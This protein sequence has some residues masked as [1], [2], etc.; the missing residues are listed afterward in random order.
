VVLAGA[1]RDKWGASGWENGALGYLTG[2]TVCG[3]VDTGCFQ[4]FQG[5]S[6][7]VSGSTVAAVVA[8]P[9][10]DAWAAT[11]WEG[12]LL[13]YPTGDRICGYL[14][15][16]CAQMFQRGAITTT[17]AAPHAVTGPVASEWTAR[18]AAGGSLGVALSDLTCGLAEGGCFQQFVGG[19]IYSSPAGAFVVTGAIGDRWAAGGWE[20]GLGYPLGDQQ[21]G[22]VNN[23]CSQAFEHGTVFSSGLTSAH[24]LSGDVLARYLALG[25]PSQLG[26]PTGEAA[27]TGVGGGTVTEFAWGPTMYSNSA[28][29]EGRAIYWSSATGAHLVEGDI[30]Q[31]YEA[32]RQVASIGYPTDDQHLYEVSPG[33]GIVDWI[34]HFERGTHSQYVLGGLVN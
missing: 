29:Y 26:Y 2:D 1:V 18:G 7:Y 17:G 4:A 16:G 8:S 3:L 23:G 30:L 12:G 33:S 5:G 20:R 27:P 19:S 15:A 11:G 32:G 25:G 28:D 10:R 9:V 14:D 22:L 24:A 31:V 34:V 6:V 13:G 21:C